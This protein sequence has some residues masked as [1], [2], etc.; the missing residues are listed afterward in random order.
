M[1]EVLDYKKAFKA[2]YQK[3]RLL[4]LRISIPISNK[5]IYEFCSTFPPPL[6]FYIVEGPSTHFCHAKP[7]KHLPEYSHCA[8]FL[9]KFVRSH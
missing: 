8:W 1:S 7:A 3:T 2:Y 6:P 4:L 5:W 9:V